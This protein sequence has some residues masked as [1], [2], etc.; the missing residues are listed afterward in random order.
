MRRLE[1]TALCAAVEHWQ[2][3]HEDAH[4]RLARAW[5]DLPDRGTPEAAALQIELSVDG[6]YENDYEQ[7]LAMGNGALETARKVGD[8]G[9]IA[10]AAS[11]L[12]LGEAVSGQIEAARTHRAEALEQIERMDDADLANRLETLYYLGWAESYLEHYDDA[13]AHAEW[14]VAIARARGEGRL[15]VPLML[16]RGYPFEMQGRLAEA[17]EM[18]ETAVEIARL[19]ANPHYLFWALW[20]LAWA[21]YF[22][23]DLDGTH[24]AGGESVRVG[25]R[26]RGG[27]MPSAGGGAGWALA[28]ASFELGEVEKARRLMWE[29]GGEEMENW[30]PVERCFNWENVALAELA[31]GNDEEADAIARRAEDSAAGLDLHLPTALAARTRAAVQLASG[32][33]AGA[34]RSA[35]TSIAAGA[36]IGATLQVAFSRSLRGRALAAAGDRPNAI[37]VLRQAERELDACGSVRMRDEA[38]RELRKL[39]ARAEARGPA[40]ADDSGVGSLTKREREISELIAERMTNKQIASQLFLSEKTIESHIRNVFNKLGASSR[41][42]VARI[43]ER[44]RRGHEESLEQ[45]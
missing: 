45:M 39:G 5:E 29:V 11:A 42:E 41:V 16:L 15:L 9:L 28:V 13:V 35:E 37:E 24:E 7:T 10:A 21:R 3:R 1:L 22:A 19:S 43:I 34:A 6:L 36:A 44:D 26:M 18:C 12:A 40:A 25:G 32:D 30:F 17:N 31:L 23:G 20:E 4:R 27:T 8:R 2:G 14:G 38:R 33:S